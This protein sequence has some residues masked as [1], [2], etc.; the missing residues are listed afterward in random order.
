MNSGPG[1]EVNCFDG[2]LVCVSYTFTAVVGISSKKDSDP[3]SYSS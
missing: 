1:P 3:G 2:K